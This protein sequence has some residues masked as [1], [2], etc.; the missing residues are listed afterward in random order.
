MLMK[1]TQQIMRICFLLFLIRKN[2]FL[3]WKENGFY[4]IRVVHFGEQTDLSLA[5][6]IFNT[7][8]QGNIYSTVCTHYTQH[9]VHSIHINKSPVVKSIA[10]YY[11]TLNFSFFR[12]CFLNQVI[13]MAPPKR[14]KK[15]ILRVISNEKQKKQKKTKEV[16]KG[17]SAYY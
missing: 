2:V 3:N 5:N 14:E 17:D 12:L 8:P 13:E 10:L 6:A 1:C 9:R 4:F 15:R 16:R 11:I 7:L